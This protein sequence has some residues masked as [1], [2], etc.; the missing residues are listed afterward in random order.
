MSY[1]DEL[2]HPRWQRRRLEILSRADFKCERCSAD[3]R[4]LHVHHKKYRRGAKPWEYAD[5]QLIALCE[6][7]HE[8]EHNGGVVTLRRVEYE[9]LMDALKSL[10]ERAAELEDL[11]YLLV[12]E[13]DME[14]RRA[15]PEEAAELDAEKARQLADL[16]AIN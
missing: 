11:Q 13:K 5:D 14:W 9:A 4:T 2:K 6:Q 16:R 12:R 7:C 15:N 1:A 10:M 8:D 3:D